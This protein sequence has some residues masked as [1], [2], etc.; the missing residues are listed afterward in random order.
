[1]PVLIAAAGCV[2]FVFP[3]PAL[4]A[5]LAEAMSPSSLAWGTAAVIGV[6]SALI[7]LVTWRAAGSA[8]QPPE[9]QRSAVVGFKR[10]A[11]ALW[12]Q[13]GTATLLVSVTS[14]GLV[15]VVPYVRLVYVA[16][17]AISMVLFASGVVRVARASGT[18]LPGM[19]L[20]LATF[21]TVWAAAT[22]TITAL[23]VYAAIS[24]SH[25]WASMQSPWPLLTPI[26]AATGIF[27]L[28]WSIRLLAVGSG[29]EKLQRAASSTL[30]V[31]PILMGSSIALL[32][33]VSS[34]TWGSILLSLSTTLTVGGCVLAASL[35][36]KAA[37]AIEA[38]P[39]LATATLRQSET[40]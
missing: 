19:R 29:D 20:A 13:L 32:A 30:T 28:L 14:G 39:A 4:Y 34:H 17:G 7:V 11:T 24:T 25:A 40:A 36:G 21:L 3:P 12:I 6:W 10:A 18:A 16:A 33:G 35:C 5:K 27:V 37:Q 2:A 26:V 23:S 38:R 15:R 22:Q 8:A 1:V 31:Y 9:D